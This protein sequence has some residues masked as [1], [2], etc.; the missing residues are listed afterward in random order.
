MAAAAM[1]SAF[2]TLRLRSMKKGKQREL[3]S[4]PRT[5]E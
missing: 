5:L 2:N 1:G 3:L 4:K